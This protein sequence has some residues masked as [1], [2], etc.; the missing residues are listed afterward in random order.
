MPVCEDERKNATVLSCSTTIKDAL[1]APTPMIA[2]L[3]R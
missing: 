2:N 3:C 1:N